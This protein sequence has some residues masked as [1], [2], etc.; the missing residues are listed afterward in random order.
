MDIFPF[1]PLGLD[2]C[3]FCVITLKLIN[4]INDKFKGAWDYH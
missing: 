2:A 3:I 1:I 4:T